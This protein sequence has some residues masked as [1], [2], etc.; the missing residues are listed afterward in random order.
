[1]RVL[2]AT[3]LF[4]ALT[5]FAA[6]SH[7]QDPQ[8]TFDLWISEDLLKDIVDNKSLL[9][10][11]DVTLGGRSKVHPLANDCE[12]HIAAVPV[13]E[14]LTA[15]KSFILEAPNLCKKKPPKG[16]TDWGAFVDKLREFDGPC[17][18]TG[19]PRILDEHLRGEETPSNPHHAFEI[20][21]ALSLVCG[22]TTL[23]AST[24]LGHFPG[25]SE[26]QPSS[27]AS[28]FD[29]TVEVRRNKAQHRIELRVDRP[30][31]CGNFFSFEMSIFTEWIRAIGG[32]GTAGHSALARVKPEGS[33]GTTSLKIY[34]MPG[35]PEDEQLA[36][37]MATPDDPHH[38]AFFHGLTTIDYF[39]IWK[40]VSDKETH[41]L[42]DVNDWT[43]VPFP[44]A[45]VVFGKVTDPNPEVDENA[46][47]P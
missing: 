25:M 27:A 5:P 17:T 26:I 33:T 46:A 19:F 28:C 11:M 10:S 47:T 16:F 39:A 20:H 14:G 6:I 40:V 23:D 44:L 29:L 4:L 42:K 7:A 15:P 36:T 31:S 21:P 32:T 35:T 45:M 9:F 18:V 12:M 8:E 43:S 2:R 1:M 22:D 34:T 37:W 41:A 38:G 24:F 30:K 13:K 3:V